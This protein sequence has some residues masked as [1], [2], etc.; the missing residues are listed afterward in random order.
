MLKRLYLAFMLAIACC[1]QSAWAAQSA[2]NIISIYGTGQFRSSEKPDWS[3]AKVE[4]ELLAGHFVRTGEYSRMGLL[5]S[6]R[7]Q[8]RLHEKTVLQIKEVGAQTRLH[9]DAG[10]AWTQSRTLPNKLYMETPSATA[11]IRGTDWDME[12]DENGRAVLTVLSGEVE[13]FNDF[14]RILVQQNESAEARVGR[15]PTKLIFVRPRDRVQWVTSHSVDP[16]RD[17]SLSGRSLGELEQALASASLAEKGRF[18]ADLGRWQEAETAMRATPA[19]TSRGFADPIGAGYAALRRGKPEEAL[20]I[21]DRSSSV[22]GRDAEL[23]ALGRAS[24]RILTEEFGQ[25]FATLTALTREAQITQPA[26]FLLLADLT[27]FAGDLEK[28]VAY[29]RQGLARFPGDARL[30]S[31]LAGIHLIADERGKSRDEIAN[32]RKNDGNSL[33]AA[34]ATGDLA[35]IEGDARASAMAYEQATALKPADDRGWYGLGRVSTEKEDVRAGRENLLKALELNSRGAGYQGELGTLESFA[36]N[37]TEARMAFDAALERNPDDYVALTGIG[38]LE[39]KRGNTEAALDALLRAGLMEPRYSRSHVYTA[40]AYYQTG[41]VKEALDELQRASHLDEKDPL[42]YFLASIIYTDT[43][44]PGLAIESSRKA[45]QLLPNL[46][47]LNQ[48][49]NDQQ[50]LTNLGYAFAFLGMEEWAQSYAQDSYY[51]FWAG[52][53]LFLADRYHGLFAKNSELFQ[54]FLSDPTV[55]GGSN[56][57]QTLIPKP[58]QNFSASQQVT[59]AQ[60][61]VHGAG[62][63]VQASGFS[64]AAMPFAYFVDHEVFDLKFAGGPWHQKT[65]TVALGLMP[66]Y[67]IGIMLYADDSDLTT[68]DSNS[69]ASFKETLRSGR[70]D[71]GLHYKFSPDSQLWFKG[72]E[73]SSKDDVVGTV[74]GNSFSMAT[75]VRN[76][77]LGLRHTFTV[78]NNHEVTWGIEE[79]HRR[80]STD[81]FLYNQIIPNDYFQFALKFDERSRDAYL[82]DRWRVSP[83][84]L[85]QG[86]IFYQRHRRKAAETDFA[87]FPPPFDIFNFQFAQPG[88]EFSQSRLNP[89]LG[90]AYRFD[91]GPQ[92]RLAYQRWMRPSLFS[93]LGPVATAGIPLDDRLVMRGGELQRRRGQ[94]EWEHSKRGF[95]SAYLDYKK[96][97]NH[98]FTITTP[99]A[100]NELESLKKL[101]PR[102]LGSLANDDMLEFVNTPEYD[103]GIINSGGVNFNQLLTEQWGVFG[104]YVAT[105]SRN[106]GQTFKG[107]EVPYLPR[108]AFA[109]GAT[110]VDPGG[111]YFISRMVH[112]SSRFSD[113]ANLA[114]LKPGW[115]G[116]F[117]LFW[118]TRDKQWLFRMSADDAFDRNRPTQYTA[119]VNLRF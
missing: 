118:Q 42:P 44:R 38:L 26:P 87:V 56:K 18:L 111:W 100:I 71:L 60:G 72:G 5:F 66:R 101:R 82:S 63:Y 99:F 83:K 78:G 96:I 55:F 105:S 97:D 75:R 64:N 41:R 98:R 49:A 94:L 36:N 58:V 74:T 95:M 65:T 80:T 92:M 31:A 81:F 30:H 10:R 1:L 119:E 70:A 109:G 24:V 17:I 21:F 40:V 110:W 25:A 67:D 57:F 89:R 34:L 104:R 23:L 51:P 113:E 69:L 103:G 112:R 28:A 62:P 115:S 59:S 88:D 35:R 102:R 50:G 45:L 79:G 46:K 52:S 32:A 4:Q 39:L 20:T 7:T 86:D 37:F 114:A 11:A 13:F 73:F 54:G 76:P 77:E 12:V 53:H 43:L 116:A 29:L 117:D 27:I 91:A 19:G 3:A 16:L 14:G 47:S 6:D 84:L 93:S 48:L 108:H 61:L 106:T 22:Q 9:L 85:V 107:N 2:A 68:S 15:A 90:L 8:L 33:E